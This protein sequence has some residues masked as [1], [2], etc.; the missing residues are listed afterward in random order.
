V[1]LADIQGIVPHA[2]SMLLAEIRRE[3]VEVSRAIVPYVPFDIVGLAQLLKIFRER[4]RD[5]LNND[6]RLPSVCRRL[7][8]DLFEST[9]FASIVRS[10]DNGE[11]A[12]LKG[13]TIIKYDTGKLVC[14]H[15]HENS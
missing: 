10:H 6:T 5:I 8:R 3:S 9:A 12:W 2:Q 4:P 7:P 13:R 15:A 1:S 14:I 11:R